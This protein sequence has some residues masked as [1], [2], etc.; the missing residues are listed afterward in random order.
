MNRREQA[1]TLLE[2]LVVIAIMTML[3]GILL[4]TISA[5]RRHAKANACLSTLKN[6][7]TAFSIYLNENRDQF[8]PVRMEKYSPTS[9]EEYVNEYN[10]AK[11]RWQWF[12]KTEYGPVIDPKPFRRL[13]RPFQDDD[14]PHHRAGTTMTNDVFT[15]PALMD[16]E[17]SH[18]VRDGA[19]GYNYQYLG[20]TRQETDPRMWDNFVVGLHQI[21]SPGQT[22]MV[23]DSRGAGRRHGKHSFTLDPPRVATERNAKTFGPTAADVPEGQNMEV[24]EFSPV[25][26][27]HNKLG[28]IVFA[29]SHAE[30]MTLT[31]LGYQ[32]SDLEHYERFPEPVLSVEDTEFTGTNRLWTGLGR[33]PLVKEQAPPPQP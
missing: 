25:E 33:D 4:P 16:D 9:T 3:M 8:P 10:R 2:L 32:F 24:F 14:L 23:A 31:Q 1:F 12:L 13:N 26:M 22:V 15:C 27:R 29:D 7:G 18:D 21:K 5:S 30:A 28:N 17:F 20:N 6:I 11:P 19:F